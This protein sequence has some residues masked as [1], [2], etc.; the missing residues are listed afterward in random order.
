M[1][2]RALS[3][4]PH[5]FT[6]VI[7]TRPTRHSASMW[8]VNEGKRRSRFAAPAARLTATVSTFGVG[9]WQCVQGVSPPRRSVHLHLHHRIRGPE[10]LAGR[11]GA[12]QDLRPGAPE[13]EPHD[14]KIGA[15]VL[16]AG[17]CPDVRPHWR[18]S[19]CYRP[20]R[21]CLQWLTV[22]GVGQVPAAGGDEL[23]DGV[24]PQDPRVKG[25]G[26]GG[27]SS[28]GAETSQSRSIPSALVNSVWSPSMASWIRRS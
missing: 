17:T 21:P 20:D 2:A 25:S 19:S 15:P 27:R 14:L 4:M 24:G 16:P 28:N 23:V 12:E 18:W 8:Y 13:G 1:S 22:V 3:A 6:A 11:I 10:W 7:K 5:K 26:V 9:R